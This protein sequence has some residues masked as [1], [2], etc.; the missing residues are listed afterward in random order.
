MDKNSPPLLTFHYQGI[1]KAGQKMEGDIQ[2]RSL[3]I[4]KADLRKQG[5][6]TNKVVKKENLCL[7]EKIKKSH[8][9]ILQCLA[10]N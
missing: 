8:K 5:I 1:N 6:V 9:Q 2:A 4:A 3:A 7:I 10:V